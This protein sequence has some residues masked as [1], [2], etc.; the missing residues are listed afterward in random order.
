M[1]DSADNGPLAQGHGISLQEEEEEDSRRVFP[2]KANIVLMMMMM[3]MMMMKV[4]FIYVYIIYIVPTMENGK[5]SKQV[6]YVRV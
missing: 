6:R 3:L 2:G 5:T 1:D 4:A